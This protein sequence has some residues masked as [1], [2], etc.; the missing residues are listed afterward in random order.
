MGKADYYADGQNNVI[1]DQCGQKYKSSQLREQWNGLY[2][3]R[4]CWDYRH[5]QEYLRGIPDNQAPALSRPE[6]PDQFTEGAQNLPE[7]PQ[8][9]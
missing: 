5:P 4:R 3:C 1:C 7:P 2:T 9:S 8:G 6:S